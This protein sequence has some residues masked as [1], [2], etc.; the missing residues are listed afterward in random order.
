ME[1]DFKFESGEILE[2]IVTKFKGVVV[3]RSSYLTGCD[4]YGLQNHKLKDGKPQ[5]WFY[6]DENVLKRC[7]GA[8]RI[9][10]FDSKET[11]GPRP[12]TPKDIHG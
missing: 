5:D 4:R 10:I 2:D 6:F 1:H 8:K 11:G 7:K 12:D 9:K 3:V